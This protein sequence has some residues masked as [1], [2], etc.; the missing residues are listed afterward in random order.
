MS[1]ENKRVIEEVYNYGFEDRFTEEDIENRH[2][3][4][5]CEIDGIALESI[6]YHILRYNRLDKDIP[7]NERKPITIYINSCGGSVVDG[8]G[9]I[10]AILASE[11]P[12]YTVN[13]A[14]CFSMGL[15]IF[16]A[17]HKRYAMPSS[18][19]LLHDGQTG[20]V[21]SSSKFKDRLNFELNQV[22]EMTKKYVISH[23]NISEKDFDSNYR[24][25]W[26]FLPIEGKELGV[27][28]YIVGTDCGLSDII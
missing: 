4:L 24:R 13:L 7:A 12:V 25:E 27:V 17:G 14:A 26:Y 16:M 28:D 3:H 21:D 5:N 11:T 20:G 2:L 23:S 1:K 10:D 19:F 9:I 18:E 8:F 6:V 22:E 15:L